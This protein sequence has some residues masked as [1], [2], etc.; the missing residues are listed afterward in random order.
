MGKERF[1][2]KADMIITISNASMGSI[3]VTSGRVNNFGTTVARSSWDSKSNSTSG[4]ITTNSFYNA[5]ESKTIRTV[6][7]DIGKLKVW[8]TEN[9]NLLS[10]LLGN[11]SSLGN[12]SII[13]IADYR[14]NS[15]TTEPG[16]RLVNGNEAAW[17]RVWERM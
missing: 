17:V 5:R 2:N 13:Y 7:I 4:F 15:S 6:Q 16:I 8:N 11:P 3:K 9:N 10:S 14:T 1:Y 12:V